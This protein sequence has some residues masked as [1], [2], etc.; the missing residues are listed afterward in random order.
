[1]AYRS[2]LISRWTASRP[3]VIVFCFFFAIAALWSL[4]TPL[5]GSPDEP[6]HFYRAYGV[7]H[8]QLVVPES[9]GPS[10]V[11]EYISVPAGIV[12]S[13]RM[14][15]CYAFNPNR[16][17][18]CMSD[19]TSNMTRVKVTS[20][21]SRYNPLYYVLVGLPSLVMGNKHLLFGMRLVAAALSAWMLMWAL[22]S[23]WLTRRP[24]I[25]TS[26]LLFG[27]TPMALFLAGM[28]NPNG[29]EITAALATWVNALLFFRNDQPEYRGMLMR[30]AAIAASI[31]VLVRSLSPVWLAVILVVSLIGAHSGLRRRLFRRDILPWLGLSLL[32]SALSVLWILVEKPLQTSTLAH[33]RHLSLAT[34]V[35][36]SWQLEGGR[37]RQ[38][39]GVFGWLDTQLRVSVY[40]GFWLVTAGAVIVALI[41]VRWRDRLALCVAAAAAIALP[42]L[43]EASTLNQERLIWQGRYSLPLSVGVAAVAAVGLGESRLLPRVGEW[44]VGIGLLAAWATV[45]VIAFGW[46]MHR[47]VAG[48][49]SPFTLSGPWQPPGGAYALMAA[50]VLATVGGCAL[51]VWYAHRLGRSRSADEHEQPASITETR[52]SAPA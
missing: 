7:A 11:G 28:V 16:T 35:H 44:I 30:R 32:A 14:T 2:A 29:L 26:A 36:M 5:W 1:M 3:S 27:V 40:H 6:E 10:G 15:H 49:R 31:L 17:A 18:Q 8:F 20:G 51:A 48:I 52:E 50:Y 39:L 24:M 25:A 47:Y 21:A 33:P 37:L 42:V 45:S 43:I 12:K 4:A 19:P 38:E 41:C 22:T 34:R 46:V 9:H 23:L 13:A